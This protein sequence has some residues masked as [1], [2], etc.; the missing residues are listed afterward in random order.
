MAVVIDKLK[1]DEV[2][3]MFSINSY[4]IIY[5]STSSRPYSNTNIRKIYNVEDLVLLSKAPLCI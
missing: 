4:D 1:N 3:V 2:E 5:T